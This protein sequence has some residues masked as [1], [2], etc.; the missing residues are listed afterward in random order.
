MNENQIREQSL[1]A[2]K[3]WGEQWKQHCKEHANDPCIKNNLEDFGATG[4]GKAILLVANG[5]SLEENMQ[6]IKQNQQ[7]VDIICCDKTLGHL[8]DNGIKPKFC[9]VCDANVD[10]DR[11]LKPWENK[12]DETIML[13]NVCANPLW[14]KNGNWKSKYFFVNKDIIKS[15]TM[16]SEMTGCTNLIPAGTNVS[17]AMLIMLTQCDN[18]GKRNYFGYDKMLLIGYDYSWTHDGK[19]YAYSN[20]GDGKANYMKHIYCVNFNGKFA[21]TSGNL[22]FSAQWLEKY[23]S[24]FRLPVVNCSKNTILQQ[25]KFGDLKEQLQY[26]FKQDDSAK[27][28]SLCEDLKKIIL[29]KKKLEHEL[30]MI[31][32]EHT[33]A[34]MA[35]V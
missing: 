22:M 31:E 10:Y 18:E 16:F 33:L 3:Q 35:S 7:M 20:D 9:L 25:T 29:M 6:T 24:T 23:I 13:I 27:A 1:A 21:Y 28:K 19:Y 8:I 30:I 15:H 14:S 17:N 12:L 5:Y 34:V 26:N 32:R 2:M 11:Y 4:I